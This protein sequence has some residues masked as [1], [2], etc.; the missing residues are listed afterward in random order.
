MLLLRFGGWGLQTAWIPVR[1]F[2]LE[3]EWQIRRV[4]GID[5]YRLFSYDK[6]QRFK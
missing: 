2:L 6:I 3:P 4:G 5:A 1:R